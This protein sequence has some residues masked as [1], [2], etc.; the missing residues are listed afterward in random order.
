MSKHLH[1]DIVSPAGS[2]FSGNAHGVR[3]PGT[4]GSFEVLLNHAPLVAT[5]D[6]GSLVVT[7]DTDERIEVAT[8]GGFLEVSENRVTVLAETAELASDI[9]VARAQKAE[10]RAVK[11]L[12]NEPTTEERTRY[13]SALDRARNRLRVAM[14]AVGHHA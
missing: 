1:V 8:S 5:I 9:D 10:E 13:E 4:A 3:A 12:E 7:S 6:V 11:A 2:I 14:G